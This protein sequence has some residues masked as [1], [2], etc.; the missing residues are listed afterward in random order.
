MS[1][2]EER[3]NR[4]ALHL[5]YRA[6]QCAANA[7]E[8]EVQ[9]VTPRQYAVLAALETGE[10]ASQAQLTQRTG[11]DRS[12]LSEVVQRMLAKGLVARKKSTTDRR[13]YTVRLTRQGRQRL[14]SVR[15]AA[16][17]VDEEVL[18][19]INPRQREELLRGLTALVGA[20]EKRQAGLPPSE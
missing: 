14:A 11:I 7:F 15:P 18:G 20:C 10:G 1:H 19:S 16:D 13:A 8:R 4:S 12:T 2:A 17:R 6:M 9:T 5:L 3:L